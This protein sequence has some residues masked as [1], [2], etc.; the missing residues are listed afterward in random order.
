MTGIQ[1]G[2]THH[3]I[4][5]YHPGLMNRALN[6]PMPCGVMAHRHRNAFAWR[7]IKYRCDD[8]FLPMHGVRQIVCL[9]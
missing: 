7:P 4:N 6:P 1:P 5:L 3:I 8:I 2:M 9:E